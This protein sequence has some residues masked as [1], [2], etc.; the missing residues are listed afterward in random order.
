MSKYTT[1]LRFICES[2]NDLE[3][4]EGYN[5]INNIISTARPQI[6]DF[7]YPIFDTNYKAVLETKILKHY[8]LYEIGCETYG[9]FKLFLDTKLNEIM[10]YYNQLYLSANIQFNP[11][12]NYEITES[13]TGDKQNKGDKQ[14]NNSTTSNSTSKSVIDSDK[15]N[16][17]TDSATNSVNQHTSDTN[18]NKSLYADTPQGDID[19]LITEKYL[20]NATI[21]TNNKISVGDTQTQHNGDTTGTQKENTN[22]NISFNDIRTDTNTSNENYTTTDTYLKSIIGKNN[23]ISN[24]EALQQ[25]RDTFLNID[26]M[27]IK[28]LSELFM[29]VF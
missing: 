8:Y 23:N 15:T 28:E 4:S 11:F 19:G 22:N 29:L 17:T 18:N 25:Y 7:D 9:L 16:I 12:N 14:S 21:D 10:P 13:Y 6:F 2:L 26:M 1:E 3:H 24:S 27:I 5:S 20:T